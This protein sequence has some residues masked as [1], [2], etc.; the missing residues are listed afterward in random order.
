MTE[1]EF[2]PPPR[3]IMNRIRVLIRD[4]ICG[5]EVQAL[6]IRVDFMYGYSAQ[7]TRDMTSV[8]QKPVRFA[9]ITQWKGM[10]IEK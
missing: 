2:V 5:P 10:I 9:L 7:Y 6:N 8:G 4:G 3:P 1:L